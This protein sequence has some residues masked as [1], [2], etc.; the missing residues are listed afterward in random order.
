MGPVSSQSLHPSS[1]LNS[2][3][4]GMDTSMEN[5][6][7][8]MEYLVHLGLGLKGLRPKDSE[9]EVLTEAH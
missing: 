7:T 9:R 5:L 6:D 2:A 1:V 8:S 4:L 3:S